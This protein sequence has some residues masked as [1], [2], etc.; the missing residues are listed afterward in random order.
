MI[1]G[2][3]HNAFRVTDMDKALA[4]YCGVL[5]FSKAFEIPDDAGN[6]WIV[7]IKVAHEQFLELFYGADCG[8]PASERLPASATSA[9]PSTTPRRSMSGSG[10]SGRSKPRSRW[11]RTPTG[12]S[13]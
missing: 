9:S 6:P 3:A 2:L 1:T 13:G 8:R 10:P 5:G 12:S 11:A 7:Y 4:F